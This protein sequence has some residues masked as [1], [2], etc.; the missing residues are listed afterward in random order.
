MTNDTNP[1][2]LAQLE[3]ALQPIKEQMVT[4][5]DLNGFSTKD[6]LIGFATKDDLQRFATKDDLRRGIAGVNAG[7]NQVL[8][9]LVNVD[10]RLTA[11]V[12]NHEH[13]IKRLE[14]KTGLVQAA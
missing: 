4:K 11:N 2:T 12:E 14:K 6:D 13:R 7:I 10:K 8:T 9:V 3:A 1:L 5:D